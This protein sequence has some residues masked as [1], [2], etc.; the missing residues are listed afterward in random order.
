MLNTSSHLHHILHDFLH[1]CI[2]NGHVNPSEARQ[3]T[4]DLAA[5][6]KE[7]VTYVPTVIMRY[8]RGTILPRH[9]QF[10]TNTAVRMASFLWGCTGILNELI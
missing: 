7:F 3:D 9:G 10:A 2:G 8:S 4:F 6:Q 1:W 5:V